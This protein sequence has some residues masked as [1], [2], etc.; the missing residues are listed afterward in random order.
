MY[1]YL[2]INNRELFIL[3]VGFLEM[4]R[5][6]INNFLKIEKEYI[7]NLRALKN[8]GD[9]SY[10]FEFR[11]S[12]DQIIKEDHSL[13]TLKTDKN[14]SFVHLNVRLSKVRDSLDD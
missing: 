3:F 1:T 10:P 4:T 6:L 5:R 12:M 2:G 8:T 9:L 14:P 7:T 11:D 13:S